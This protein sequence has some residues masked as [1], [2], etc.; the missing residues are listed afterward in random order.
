MEA[1]ANRW[2]SKGAGREPLHSWVLNGWL[3]KL[4]VVEKFDVSAAEMIILVNLKAL[5]EQIWALMSEYP[6]SKYRN[7]E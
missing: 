2:L 7:Y 6:A 4:P 3:R 1:E 5:D